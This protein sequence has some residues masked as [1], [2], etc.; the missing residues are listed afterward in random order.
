[1]EEQIRIFCYTST[2]SAT[3]SSISAERTCMV[4]RGSALGS[5]S[6]LDDMGYDIVK[7][8]AGDV[9]NKALIDTLTNNMSNNNVLRLMYKERKR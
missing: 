6:L 1:M 9:R 3:I 8:D 4:R 5:W 7:Y 2:T